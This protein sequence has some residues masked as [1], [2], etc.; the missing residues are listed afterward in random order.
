[1][2]KFTMNAKKLKTMIEKGLIAVD[3]KTSLA[4]LHKLYLQVEG[5][6]TVKILGTDMEHFVEMRTHSAWNTSPGVIGIDI[7]DIKIISKMNGDVTIEDVSTEEQQ[8]MNVK[9]GKKIVTLPCV[10]NTD[11][12]LPVMDDTEKHILI[13]EENWLLTTIVNLSLFVPGSDINNKMLNTFHFN[14][15]Q[16][17]VEVCDG[18]RIGMRTIDN[19]QIVTKSENPFDNIKL[20]I[21]CLPVLKKVMDKKSDTEVKI[22]QDKKFIK[23]EGKNFTYIIRRVEGQYFNLETMLTNSRE[24]V[25]NAD[26]KKMLEVMQ[27]NAEMAKN[28]KKPTIFHS[29]NGK[30]YSFLK[31]S[32]YET[33]DEIEVGNFTMNEDLFIGFNSQYLVD[34]LSIVDTDKPMFRGEHNKAPMYIDGNEYNFMILPIYTGHDKDL[35][36]RFKNNINKVA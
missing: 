28:E 27:Y 3:K 22:Y 18:H 5:D 4:S 1:M 20:H 14:V 19:Q 10:T 9:C 34:A 30:L 23:L 21:K 29:E 25:F 33:F 13:V 11:I 15:K 36:S 8:T 17:R 16:R 31:T 7:N 2:L 24:F 6:E 35:I 26:R 32:R 12:F